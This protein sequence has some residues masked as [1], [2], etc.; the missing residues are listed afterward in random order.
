[1]S[2]DKQNLMS[3][4]QKH[5]LKAKNAETFKQQLMQQNE[6]LKEILAQ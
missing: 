3:E 2:T 6:S 1:M 5:V 4:I